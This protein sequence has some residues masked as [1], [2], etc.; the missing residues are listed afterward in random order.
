MRRLLFFM[1][2]SANGLYERARWD[3]DWHEVDD[4]FDVF[5]VDQ[6]SS[7]ETLLFGRVTYEGMAGFW[8]TPEAIAADPAVAGRMNALP[9]LVFSSTLE[10]ADWHNSRLIKED[11]ATAVARM[12]AEGGG[13]AIIL[14]SSDLSRTLA[15]HDLI[16]EYRLMVNPLFLGTG[17]PVL[18]GLNADLELRLHAVRTFGNGNVLL[19]YRP[20]R[21]A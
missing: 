8:P 10:S 18:L 1:M 20:R 3:V 16:D 4:E 11:P 12:K 21:A 13:D 17:K 6:L 19:T 15:E 14:A 9:K 5:A 7:V 2:V